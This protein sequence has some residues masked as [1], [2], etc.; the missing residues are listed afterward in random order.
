MG[1][2]KSK[3]FQGYF[4]ILWTRAKESKIKKETAYFTI[5]VDE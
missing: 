2:K 5:A 1:V 3:S 4:L